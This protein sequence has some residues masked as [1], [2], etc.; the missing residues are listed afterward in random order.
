MDKYNIFKKRLEECSISYDQFEKTI[1]KIVNESYE[2]YIYISHFDG[3]GN[4]NSDFDIYV[5]TE[6]DAE[7]KTY[8]LKIQKAKL[9]IE[10]WNIN[11]FLEQLKDKHFCDDI[12]VLKKLYRMKVSV[13]GNTNNNDYINTK[14]QDVLSTINLEEMIYE[15]FKVMSNSE[16][17][18]AVNMFNSC[19]YVSSLEC[20]RRAVSNLLA[21][22]NIQNG[23]IVCNLKWVEK[24]F[25][26]HSGK[27]QQEYL[28]SF[29]YICVSEKNIE[30]IVERMLDFVTVYSSRLACVK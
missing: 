7:H 29:V 4:K 22:Y 16:Y 2:E 14:I 5:I 9:D 10:V 26:K 15:Y 30:H 11:E 17:K 3:V 12:K 24:L 1:H 25:L 18:N 20:C 23:D 19:E 8:M 13:R 28:E 27:M 21:A 6:D